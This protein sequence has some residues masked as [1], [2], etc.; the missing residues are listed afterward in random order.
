MDQQQGRKGQRD[1]ASSSTTGSSTST[2]SLN[3]KGSEFAIGNIDPD[4]IYKVVQDAFTDL[5]TTYTT[6]RK[7]ALDMVSTRPFYA[8]ASAAVI[9]LAAGLALRNQIV[10]ASSNKDNQ[11]TH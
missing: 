9:G 4:Q 10:A 11:S 7:Q 6:V 3:S 5:N 8:L 1:T 2:E